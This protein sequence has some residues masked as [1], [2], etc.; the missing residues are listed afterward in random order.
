MNYPDFSNKPNIINFNDL[1]FKFYVYLEVKDEPGVLALIS[2][3]FADHNISFDK[4]IQKDQL[5]NGSVPLVIFTDPTIESEM[6][7]A[8]EGLADHP[9]VLNSKIIR[10]EDL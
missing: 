1:T 10:I 7:I 8:L 5:Q 9:E 3:T 4:V 6:Q 2:K